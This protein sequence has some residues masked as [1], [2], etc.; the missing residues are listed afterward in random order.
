[1]I[2]GLG[3]ALAF[4]HHRKIVHPDFKPANAFITKDNHVKVLDFGIARAIKPP[5]SSD[6]THFD[7]GKLG[8][9]TPA[10]ASYE[11]LD[12]DPPDPRD[13]IY[14]LGAVAYLLL[15]GKRPV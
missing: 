15:S 5:G 6:T 2:K 10:Y 3:D 4:A 11:M 12:G 14:A 7:A 8:A 13:D 9:L 1:M